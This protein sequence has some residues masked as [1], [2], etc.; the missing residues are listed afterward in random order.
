VAGG[1]Y[2][3]SVSGKTAFGAIATF[4]DGKYA[5]LPTGN[6]AAIDLSQDST[7]LWVMDQWV[8]KTSGRVKSA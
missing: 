6:H 8:G 5:N 7:G 1:L 2:A 4:K 3:A